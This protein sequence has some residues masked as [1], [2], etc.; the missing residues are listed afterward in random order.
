MR[1]TKLRLCVAFLVVFATN[2]SVQS[3]DWPMWRYDAQR[4]ASSPDETLPAKLHLQWSR[5]CGPALPAWPEE[6]R[7]M[8]DASHEPVVLGQTMFVGSAQTES[9]TPTRRIGY[10]H[11]ESPA[12]VVVLS[13]SGKSRLG[14]SG[15]PEH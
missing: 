15:K 5:D 11:C 3:A 12:A 4:S 7:L 14:L 9:V 13:A 10:N 6:P 8:F 1:L 2:Q